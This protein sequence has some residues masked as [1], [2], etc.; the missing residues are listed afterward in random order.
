MKLVET[1]R[2]LLQGSPQVLGLGGRRLDA[3]YKLRKLFAAVLD[4]GH[5]GSEIVSEAA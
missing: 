1:L 2:R 3:C 4:F 5:P